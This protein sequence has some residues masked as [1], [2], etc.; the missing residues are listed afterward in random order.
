MAAYQYV[1]VMKDLT[2]AYPGGREVFKGITLS[3]LPG[4]KIGVQPGSWSHRI[5]WFGPVLGVMRAPDFD[6]AIQWQNGVEYGLTAGIHALD[7]AECETWIDRIEAGNAYVNRGTTGAVV[8]RQPFG[9]WKKSSVGPTAKAGG[10]NYVACLR[11]WAPGEAALTNDQVQTWWDEV[12]G[13]ARDLA[14]L[15]VERNL[16]RLRPFRKAVLVRVDDRTRPQDL[17]SVRRLS[18]RTGTPIQLSGPV[19]RGADTIVET[20]E[21]ARARIAAKRRGIRAL[22]LGKGRDTRL[23]LGA[24]GKAEQG[25]DGQ[26]PEQQAGCDHVG[27]LWQ[28]TGSGTVKHTDTKMRSR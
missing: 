17:E 26:G 8:N 14:G 4:V 9:G 28:K 19:S 1:Y 15:T 25:E 24:G 21:Q 23:A 22:G 11:D 13:R 12:G 3:F 10:E 5:E 20:V 18:A 2:K 7:V 27:S 6:T 16:V